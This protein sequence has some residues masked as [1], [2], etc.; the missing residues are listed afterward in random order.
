MDST[1]SY[2]LKQGDDEYILS[3]TLLDQ[4]VKLSVEDTIK[5]QI[6]SKE[7]SI[8]D[9]K[10][11]DQIFISIQTALNIIEIFDKILTNDKV[12]IQ[13]DSE[14]FQ[15][16][17]YLTSEDRQ[18]NI[19]LNPET[20]Q[21]FE[22]NIEVNKDFNTQD[23]NIQSELD[24]N[25]QEN[26]EQY[27]N[28]NTDIN[29]NDN[30]NT[31]YMENVDLN[32]NQYASEN[33]ALNENENINLN[34]ETTTNKENIIPQIEST[35]IESTTNIE[36]IIPPVTTT[37][38]ASTT[39]IENIIPP[40]TTKNIE[41]TTINNYFQNTETITQPKKEEIKYT[42]PTIT[43][44]VDDEPQPQ[45]QQ[46]ETII[47]PV[48]QTTT[49]T[50][51]STYNVSLSLP[52][53]NPNYKNVSLSL[54]KTDNVD[55]EKIKILKD[56][57]SKLLN[58]ISQYNFKIKELTNLIN[59]YKN[60]ISSALQNTD[61]LESLRAENQMIK[62]QLDELNRLKKEAEEAR[63][64][65]SQ[66]T[67][68]EPLRKKAAEVEVIKTQLL[69]LNDLK[70]KLAELSGVQDQ[71]NEMKRLKEEI[72]K[73]SNMD[74]N[75]DEINNL[76]MQIMQAEKLMKKEG[77][78]QKQE[79]KSETHI[80]TQTTKK[81]I[82]KGDIIHNLQ[83]LE[84]ITRKINKS[85]SKIILNL[86][87]KATYDSDSA[88]AFHQK[89][90]HAESSLVLIESD[91]G[92]R[93]G[94]FTTQNWRGDGEEKKDE[95]AFVFSLDKMKAYDVI[96]DEVAIG[97]YPKFGPI[98][99]GCQIRIYDNAFKNGGTTFEKG[100]N[101]STEEDY[102]LTDGDRAF[103]VREIEVYEVIVE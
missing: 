92:K 81:S 54:P 63:Y 57:Q 37:N 39:N 55:E 53:K 62:Q 90:D 36:N 12:R 66:L 88:E 86:I 46:Q 64:I 21:N 35:N 100:L 33:I 23:L 61:E 49:T 76:K 7:Y 60:Q 15:V 51:T 18:I 87:Y 96:E 52:K 31:N 32:M 26:Y 2:K 69:E 67:E 16:I 71:L 73:L 44:V 11:L 30:I 103:G 5:A 58:S 34:I 56:E 28:I 8:E 3:I 41:S 10:A 91:K 22:Q 93:F 13:N 50:T 75:L 99:L 25:V 20:P 14:G 98:F 47:P 65:K 59:S 40:V 27:K 38:I 79:I 6:F 42:L 101:F 74:N 45:P 4:G 77:E 95:N 17:L 82:I 9:M 83:E 68:L 24:Q 1:N 29:A 43:P 72:N 84:M 89:C 70:M 85:N 97:C 48:T 80:K 78:M 19:L 102:E 94:G